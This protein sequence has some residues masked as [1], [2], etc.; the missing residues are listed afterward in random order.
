MTASVNASINRDV[1][2][3]A[4]G[5]PASEKPFCPLRKRNYVVVSGGGSLAR[6]GV[7]G[8]PAPLPPAGSA[9]ATDP[10]IEDVQEQQQN[11]R[12]IS[13]G[14]TSSSPAN[15]GTPANDHAWCTPWH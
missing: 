12:D 11:S 6:W 4:V 10:T 1:W 7:G 9:T 8:A 13:L 14:T 5:L 2:S 15:N 3:E